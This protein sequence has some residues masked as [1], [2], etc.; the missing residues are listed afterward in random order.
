[1]FSDYS[2]RFEYDRIH[3]APIDGN[4][5]WSLI[6]RRYVYFTTTTTTSR[7]IGW[8]WS[9][10]TL[11]CTTVALSE[12]HKNGVCRL[13]NAANCTR[14][15]RLLRPPASVGRSTWS[16]SRSCSVCWSCWR[17]SPTVRCSWGGRP[18]A[19]NRW[20]I[21]RNWPSVSA[22]KQ[23]RKPSKNKTHTAWNV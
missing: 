10:Q 14:V 12:T 8:I 23:H 9:S 18:T 17:A 19:S 2:G 3:H 22:K 4:D 21:V 7:W 11:C 13:F 5:F 20:R 6:F 16:A 15:E 1:M